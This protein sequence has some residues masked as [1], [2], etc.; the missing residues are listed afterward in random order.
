MIDTVEEAII[1]LRKNALANCKERIDDAVANPKEKKR[2]P[3]RGITSIMKNKYLLVLISLMFI[4]I[5]PV[6]AYGIIQNNTVTTSSIIELEGGGSRAPYA[7]LG[8]YVD[9]SKVVGWGGEFGFWYGYPTTGSRPDIIVDASTFQHK[10][11]IDPSKYRVGMWYKWDGTW[12][13]SAY[14]EAFE[15]RPGIRPVAVPTDAPGYNY[16]GAII[17][18]I[19]TPIPYK[20]APIHLVIARGDELTYTYKTMTGEKRGFIWLFGK[21]QSVLGDEMELNESTYSYPF[22]EEVTQNLQPGW[23]TGYLQFSTGRPSV[24]YNASHKVGDETVPILETPYDDAAVPDVSL[25]GLLPE[26]IQSDFE[27]L[28]SNKEYSTDQ[29]IKITMEVVDPS[30]QFTDYY[31]ENDYIVIQGKSSMAAGTNMSFVIDPDHY[32]KGYSL[33]SHTFTTE[34][35]GA[36]NEQRTFRMAMPVDWEEISIGEHTV[37]VT[38]DKLKIHLVQKKEFDVKSIWVNPT[39]IPVTEKVII[40]GDGWHRVNVTATPT[41]TPEIVYVTG[42]PQ[43]VYVYITNTTTA[44]PTAAL[45]VQ[46]T[47]EESPI[48]GTVAIVALVCVAYIVIRKR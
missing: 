39:P 22:R 13:D 1:K 6:F 37:V 4:C 9:I 17:T 28:Q 48:G 8:E 23:Y 29:L 18:P 2:I 14:S 12:E 31:E 15:I 11:W 41:P 5:S 3:Q 47:A 38:L 34:L 7:Y 20:E 30:I 16:T 25:A 21:L 32:M 44:A 27:L 10:Y 35:E 45:P 26:H 46:T 42:T 36:I 40:D 19:I 24:W 43:I 33:S